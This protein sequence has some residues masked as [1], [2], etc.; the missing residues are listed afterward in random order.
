MKKSTAA[1]FWFG[2]WDVGI[3]YSRA[4]IQRTI[5][6]SPA[7]FEHGLAEKIAVWA[8]ANWDPNKQEVGFV[9]AWRGSELW[10]L[11]KY[12][13]SKIKNKKPTAVDV[14]SWPNGTTLMQI[15]SGQMVLLKDNLRETIRW[16]LNATFSTFNHFWRWFREDFTEV[17]KFRF[18]VLF[19]HIFILNFGWK[20]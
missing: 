11:I 7:F 20:F 4:V 13:R 9:F 16:M 17:E 5:D 1:L 10:T 8:Y 12:T 18:V 19:F 3:L 6:A 15:Q 14:F 2:L